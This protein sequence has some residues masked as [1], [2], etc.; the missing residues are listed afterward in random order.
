M[1]LLQFHCSI[2]SEN[3]ASYHFIVETYFW[4]SGSF[5][6]SHGCNKCK[7]VK[8]N[9]ELLETVYVWVKCHSIF[10][11][12]ETSESCKESDIWHSVA[13]QVIFIVFLLGK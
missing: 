4:D 13:P 3:N 2:S 8:F 6:K 7:Y 12:L 9:P 10:N 5:Y 1:L 11:L